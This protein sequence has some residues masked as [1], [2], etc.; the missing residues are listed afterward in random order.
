MKGLVVTIFVFAAIP[1]GAVE[2]HQLDLQRAIKES[3]KYD[4]KAISVSGVA[5][6]DKDYFV[7]YANISAARKTNLKQAIFVRQ[8]RNRPSFDQY[9]RHWVQITG[10]MNADLHGP[11]GFG[12]PCEVLLEGIR[13]LGGPTVNLW[14]RDEGIFQN[15]TGEN[16]RITYFRPDGYE[17]IDLAPDGL[18]SMTVYDKKELI[19]TNVRGKVI[20]KSVLSLPLRAN[21][22]FEQIDRRFFYVITR[23]GIKM[24]PSISEPRH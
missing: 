14:L 22:T 16:I 8:H 4:G 3:R 2:I 19:A 15:K 1:L 17:K 21:T 13:S 10:T 11:L 20:C 18:S 7:L 24:V 9:H 6:V 5:F 12:F 23:N